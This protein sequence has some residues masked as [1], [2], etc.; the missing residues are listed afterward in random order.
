MNEQERQRD[1][2]GVGEEHGGGQTGPARVDP[3]EWINCGTLS[4]HPS[5]PAWYLA[6]LQHQSRGKATA[7]FKD[8]IL[9]IK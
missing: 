9:G 3:A 8:T 4:Q 5:G 2:D 6:E 1:Q 7:R